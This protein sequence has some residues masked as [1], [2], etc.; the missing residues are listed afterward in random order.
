M[1]SSIPV[2]GSGGVPASAPAAS[3]LISE[4]KHVSCA[5]ISFFIFSPL[6][7]TLLQ[8]PFR[9]KSTFLHLPMVLQAAVL[10]THIPALVP[11]P[12]QLGSIVPA[13]QTCAAGEH[14]CG[15][16]FPGAATLCAPA[17]ACCVPLSHQHGEELPEAPEEAPQCR[18]YPSTPWQWPFGCIT[19][20]HL[21]TT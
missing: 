10:T 1:S 17:P 20:N 4:S 8:E 14:C 9:D 15:Q 11:V 18:W 6:G 5:S 3:E 13:W 21:G 12:R 2:P 19:T 7:V 16:T